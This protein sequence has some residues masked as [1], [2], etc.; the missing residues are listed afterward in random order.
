MELLGEPTPTLSQ[1]NTRILETSHTTRQDGMAVGGS[2]DHDV[3]QSQIFSNQ[4][5]K[6]M[7]PKSRASFRC[8]KEISCLEAREAH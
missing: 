1:E 5:Q 4:V 8:R 7:D 3:V 2:R 6:L